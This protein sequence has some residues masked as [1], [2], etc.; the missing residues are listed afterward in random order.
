M[1][2]YGHSA[3]M[4]V[5]GV[6]IAALLMA[7][8]TVEVAL[9]AGQAPSPRVGPASDPA[10]AADGFRQFPG[11][12]LVANLGAGLPPRLAAAA[13]RADAD[14]QL[15][16]GLR[17]R[18]DGEPF[19]AP[20]GGNRLFRFGLEYR[21]I[22]LAS[23]STY[24][25][26]VGRNGRLLSSRWQNVPH[27]VDA[28]V[29]T[30]AVS[31]ALA[32]AT[33]HARQTL[34]Q[35]GALSATTP[36][37]EVW[38]DAQQAGRLCWSMTV[39]DT[40]D[41]TLRG[42][43]GYRIAAIDAP[44][45]LSS[46]DAV[47]YDTLHARVD[48]WDLSPN[49]PTVT[50]PL[51][52]AR[53]AVNGIPATTDDT[54]TI[55][56]G[57]NAPGVAQASLNG[58]FANVSNA[59]G[60][61]YAGSV[62]TAGG[63]ETLSFVATT[64]FALA[65][66]TGFAWATYGNRWA[67][68]FLPFLNARATALDGLGVVVNEN[69]PCNA[70]TASGSLHFGRATPFCNNMATPTVVLH[71]FGHALHGTLAGGSIEPAFSEGFGDAIAALVTEQPCLGPGVSPTSAAC[72]RDATEV[73][74]WPVS[75]P[76]VHEIGKPFAQFAW[77]LAGDIG[78]PAATEIVLG[79]AMGAPVDV[80][81]AIR[82]SFVADDDDGLLGTCSPHQHALQAAAD[83]R[84]LPRPQNCRPA[85]DN[86]PPTAR[87]D[88]FTLV[89][90]GG[91]SPIDLLGNDTDPD[92]D[93]LVVSVAQPGLLG[94][95]DCSSRPC[96]YEPRADANGTESL[97]YTVIDTFGGS[98]TAT[99]RIQIAPVED[100]VSVSGV[101]DVEGVEDAPT[102]VLVSVADPDGP[103]FTIRWFVGAAGAP[104]PCTFAN[105]LAASTSL[106]CTH[107]GTFPIG[108]VVAQGGTESVFP[109]GTA[110]IANA[111]PSI[112]ITAPAAGVSIPEQ[113]TVSLAATFED[114]PT[115]GA[116]TCEIGWGDGT[117]SV[118][119]T[120]AGTCTGTHVYA[121]G[122][123][124]PRQI[125]V[126]VTDPA[127]ARGTASVPIV[128]TSS[129]LATCVRRPGQTCTVAGLGAVGRNPAVAF[130]FTAGLR[131]TQPIGQL[132]LLDGSW[133]FLTVGIRALSMSGDRATMA[134]TGSLNGRPGYTFE[135]VVVDNRRL[136]G[137]GA[138]ADTVRVVI[139][140]AAN[141]IVRVVDGEVSR[142]D[143]VVD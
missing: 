99:V 25:A 130:E 90:D 72:L 41:G 59:A 65:Q 110:A 28:T 13:L 17:L 20:V 50:A 55:V 61:R 52:N 108:V 64:E 115:A 136:L 43:I 71:E 38:V 10:Q 132:L 11:G 134:G 2:V 81:D 142:G 124:G 44:V 141:A 9:S 73:T 49:L 22:A 135:A 139:R 92:G 47:Q 1:L 113:S 46:A 31:T 111:R 33:A 129:G 122:S 3:R 53:L 96:R 76:D 120:G 75:S 85:G 12:R 39:R 40:V 8:G 119:L 82:L 83:S 26:I 140:D 77:A 32:A 112:V 4:R 101:G 102:P 62:A 98:A 80:P 45:V 34:A 79:A 105:P 27:A 95:L 35:S 21:G 24:V 15:P 133:R 88:A 6:A 109:L 63:D 116:H 7:T 36:V 69:R 103:A 60:P 58:P 131:N 5:T 97:S 42:A 137:R 66:T 117:T 51:W 118:G 94:T 89:E 84:L 56:I 114:G 19:V 100:A 125:A 87:D 67:R 14:S 54:G 93:Q 91:D 57:A 126:S 128:I 30:I 78:F 86:Q 138:L 143:V 107:E 18:D 121:A 74:M 48:V 37:L 70:I 29:P 23:A 68:A 104:A 123:A 16:A 127:L 106:T